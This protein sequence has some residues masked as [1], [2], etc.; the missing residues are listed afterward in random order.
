M[1]H[2]RPQPCTM[3]KTVYFLGLAD[4]TEPMPNKV[5]DDIWKG[6]ANVW[7]RISEISKV[8]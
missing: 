2:Q 1:A 3:S 8:I 5:A 4:D 6:K 7:V